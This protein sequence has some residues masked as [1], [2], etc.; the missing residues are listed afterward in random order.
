MDVER[1]LPLMSKLNF[2]EYNVNPN[3][4]VD[5]A[6]V[7]IKLR[8]LGF[9]QISTAKNE[10]ATMWA[11]N[12]CVLLL[13][14]HENTSTGLSGLGVNTDVAPDNSRHC[15]TT[16]MN[17]VKDVNGLNIY[18]FPLSTFKNTYD[19][20]FITMHEAGSAT[21]LEFYAGVVYRSTAS[22]NMFTSELRFKEVKKTPDFITT[23]CSLN[24]F[25]ILWDLHNDIGTIDTLVIK[26]NDISDTTAK[27]IANGFESNSLQPQRIIDIEQKYSKDNEFPP[28]H[29]VKGWGLNLGGTSKSYVLEKCFEN[30]L[31][32]LDIIISERHNHN[33]LNQETLM[34]YSTLN[35]SQ[36]EEQHA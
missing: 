22:M 24:R 21:S 19:K 17:I 26:T 33:G 27:M 18:S 11:L 14:R 2:L 36:V 1:V 25:N 31:P 8:L 35:T 6:D 30:A 7:I 34:Y 29:F 28:M 3:D 5:I 10:K 16:G 15:E 9:Q 32:N 23:A 12:S 20:H 4:S 13:S